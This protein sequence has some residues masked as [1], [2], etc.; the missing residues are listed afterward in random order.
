[1]RLR[2]KT[3]I[4]LTITLLVLAVVGVNSWLYIARLTQQVVQQT[5]NSAILVRTQIFTQVNNALHDAER[6]G[7]VPA[8]NSLADLRKYFRNALDRSAALTSLIDAGVSYPSIYEVTI[9]DSDGVAFI[10]S[11]ASLRSI[12]LIPSTKRV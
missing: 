9:V 12:A 4:T 1:M 10:S 5:E 11:D 6:E 3:K 8:S 2:L 7:Q